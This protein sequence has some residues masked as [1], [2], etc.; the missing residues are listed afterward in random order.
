MT[1]TCLRVILFSLAASTAAIPAMGAPLVG[2]ALLSTG[3]IIK[4]DPAAPTPFTAIGI[5]GYEPAIGSDG[6]IYAVWNNEVLKVDKE[7]NVTVHANGILVNTYGL[8]IDADD[9][10]FVANKSS[11][12]IQKIDPNGVVTIFSDSPLLNGPFD[13]VFDGIGRLLASNSD[14]GNILRFDSAGNATVFA[15]GV[16]VAMGMEFGPNGDLFVVSNV[17]AEVRRV[18]PVGEVSLFAKTAPMNHPWD[19]GFDASGHVYV[20][21][22]WSSYLLKLNLSGQTLEQVS[23]PNGARGHFINFVVPEPV[24]NAVVSPL[25]PALA[26]LCRR[27]TRMR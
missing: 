22:Y 17:A 23:L 26:L 6:S 18:S 14:G 12:S 13:L 24:S 20:A 3:A 21:S 1:S 19:V 11:N 7:G 4:F 10:L 9:N 2:Q 5:P 15:T 27:Q 8:A 16:G 25:L